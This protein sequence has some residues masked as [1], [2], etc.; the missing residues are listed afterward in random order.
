MLETHQIQLEFIDWRSGSYNWESWRMGF[1]N[2]CKPISKSSTAKR[3]D[4]VFLI[5]FP[6]LWFKKKVMAGWQLSEA[7]WVLSTHAC[8]FCASALFLYSFP[9]NYMLF[10]GFPEKTFLS[11]TFLC[12]RFSAAMFL[13]SWFV[14][15]TAKRIPVYYSPQKGTDTQGATADNRDIRLFLSVVVMFWGHDLTGG[16]SRSL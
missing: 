16:I 5:M 12:Q 13:A 8:T 7:P 11:L 3:I 9:L 6:S 14:S 15:A 10:M 2:I 4:K 1:L